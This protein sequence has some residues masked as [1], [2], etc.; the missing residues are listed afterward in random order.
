MFSHRRPLPWKKNKKG[1]ANNPWDFQHG[2]GIKTVHS[3]I[4]MEL[5][6]CRVESP[7][8]CLSSLSCFFIV[9]LGW[10]HSNKTTSSLSFLHDFCHVHHCMYWQ[11]KTLIQDPAIH[12]AIFRWF[13]PLSRSRQPATIIIPQQKMTA[14]RFILPYGCSLHLKVGW[15]RPK[16]GKWSS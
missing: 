3:I 6:Q 10:R 12:W 8:D 15:D 1:R 7:R 13:S 11:S 5:F 4:V 14:E 2:I 9:K 16:N